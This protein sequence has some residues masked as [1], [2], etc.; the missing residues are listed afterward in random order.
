MK[1]TDN[2]KASSILIGQQQYSPLQKVVTK[3]TEK[4]Q[5]NFLVKRDDLIH[6]QISGN[7]WRKLKHNLIDAKN[8]NIKQLI[9]FG[10]AYSNHIHAFSAAGKIFGFETIGIIRGEEDLDNPTIRAARAAG[11]IIHYV[12]RQ[13][14][15][16]RQDRAYLLTLNQRHP[17]AIIIPEGGT[18]LSALR[19][20]SEIVTE[21][22]ECK[23][24]FIC[25]PCGSGGT[26]AGLLVGATSQT[27]IISVPVLKNAQYL[28]AEIHN[29]IGQLAIKN[30]NWDFID[31]YHFGGY[32]KVKPQLLNFIER[33]HRET[34][35]ELEPIYS[36]KMFYALFDLMAQG[37]FPKNSTVV[38]IHTGG[39]QGVNGLKQRGLLPQDWLNS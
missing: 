29:L 12:T 17:D 3:Q 20:V 26:T 13:Q 14:Y 9:T 18:N 36:G 31:G 34:Q 28:I 10:G 2:Y 21:L 30:D 27:K 35:I 33:F 11:M 38:A 1:S 39:L 23:P 32:A 16:K 5:I 24:D 6:P 8:N 25:T 37:Y 4:Y 19:G 15:K 22:A 7:K